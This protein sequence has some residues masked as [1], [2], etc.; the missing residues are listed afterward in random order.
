MKW[1][2]RSLEVGDASEPPAVN[3]E[4]FTVKIPGVSLRM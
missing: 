3:K 2:S 4:Y 1:H